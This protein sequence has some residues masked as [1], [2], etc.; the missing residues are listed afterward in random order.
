MNRR[1][2]HKRT[3]ANANPEQAAKSGVESVGDMG[4][5]KVVQKAWNKKEK[6]MKSTKALEIVD[7][8]CLIQVTTQQGD[9]VA[10]A[11]CYV[12][13]AKLVQNPAGGGTLVRG[14][15]YETQ[16]SFTTATQGTPISECKT[17]WYGTAGD[18]LDARLKLRAINAFI[19]D[20]WKITPN[21]KQLDA[22]LKLL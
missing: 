21:S 20:T 1:H 8:G 13:G 6:W 16:I 15:P 12:P 5:W 22:L 11:V 14:L 10:E 19:R 17:V 2:I 9:K 7:L 18:N 3:V 4:T